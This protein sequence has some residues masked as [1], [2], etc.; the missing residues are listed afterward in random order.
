MP[1]AR[2][3]ESQYH[4]IYLNRNIEKSHISVLFYSKI[5]SMFHL[6]FNNLFL[7][8]TVLKKNIHSC[9]KLLHEFILFRK[10]SFITAIFHNKLVISLTND[11]ANRFILLNCFYMMID[12]IH[13]YLN[14]T[15]MF[16]F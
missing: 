16:F 4:F 15:N 2:L 5:S 1:L 14:L 12:I 13:I 3:R 11:N 6:I 7:I 10:Y 9:E 8:Y